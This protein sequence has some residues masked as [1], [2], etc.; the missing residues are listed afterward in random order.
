MIS[1]EAMDS[2]VGRIKVQVDKHGGGSP[3]LKQVRTL[4]TMLYTRRDNATFGL[5]QGNLTELEGEEP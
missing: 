5:L 2:L 3:K 4:Y 1:Q